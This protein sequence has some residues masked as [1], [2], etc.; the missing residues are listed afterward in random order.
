MDALSSDEQDVRGLDRRGGPGGAWGN[1]EMIGAFLAMGRE[2]AAHP[3]TRDAQIKA[4]YRFAGWQI[5]S[6]LS[7]EVITPWIGGL[8]V[9]MRRGMTGATGNYYFGLHEFMSMGLMIH[10]L[11]EGDLFVDVGANVGSYTLLGSGICGARTL[12]VEADPATGEHL[13]RNVRLNQIG[14]LVTISL[15]ALGAQDG[16]AFF[17][18]SLDSMNKVVSTDGGDVRV[19]PQKTLDSVVG[20][21]NPAALKLDVEGHEEQV[22][23]GSP[24]VLANPSLKLIEIE[25]TTPSILDI[26]TDNGFERAFYDPFTRALQREPNELAYSNGKWTPSNEF[27]VRDWQSVEKRV[28]DAP[29]VEVLGRAL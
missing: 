2:I 1:P 13:A 3:L 29:P 27:F 19:V 23:R 20:A 18:T 5:K 4:W 17:T 22:L 16:T 15:V 24:Q 7:K 6:R 14:E 25:G 8:R 10:F 28:A 11:R 26:L 21:G 12:A 9:A